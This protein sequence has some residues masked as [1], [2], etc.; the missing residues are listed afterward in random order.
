MSKL[1]FLC[2]SNVGRSQMAE[3][4]YNHLTGG[5]NSISAAGISDVVRLKDKYHS[6]PHEGIIAVMKER[7][8]DI[9]NQTI[10]FVTEEMVESSEKVIVLDE[11]IDQFPEFVQRSKKLIFQ[12]IHDPYDD[13]QSEEER[14]RS[15]RACRCDVEKFLRKFRKADDFFQITRPFFSDF[16]Q[17]DYSIAELCAGDGHAGQLFSLE[18]RV[19]QVDFVDVRLVRGLKTTASK[20]KKLYQLFLD[21]L[22]N[23]SLQPGYA[24]IA[25]HACGDLTDAILEKAVEARVPVAVMPCC[26]TQNMKKYGLK[27]SPDSRLLLYS[28]IEDYHDT[29]RLQFLHE[30]GYEARIER[31]DP[32]ITPMNNVLIGWSIA[33]SQTLPSLLLPPDNGSA[34][35]QY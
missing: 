5:K 16:F 21:G 8:I 13:N 27:T 4:F 29:V 11:R 15:F 9:S 26:Y 17:G 12:Y 20:I 3:G 19:N 7:G 32:R 23:Y 2:A 1:L 10:D 31:I 34:Y 33:G 28:R 14:R 35:L 18:E 24:A 6:R 22:E 25:V 30:Q